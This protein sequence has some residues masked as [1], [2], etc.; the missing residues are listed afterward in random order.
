LQRNIKKMKKLRF[1]YG[2]RG[3]M[4]EVV[5]SI[6][7]KAYTQQEKK[8]AWAAELISATFQIILIYLVANILPIPLLA[9]SYILCIFFESIL[10]I[11]LSAASRIILALKDKNKSN[12]EIRGRRI[13]LIPS[14]G[15]WFSLAVIALIVWGSVGFMSQRNNH[16]SEKGQVKYTQIELLKLEQAEAKY[17]ADTAEAGTLLMGDKND[18]KRNIEDSFKSKFEAKNQQIAS[19]QRAINEAMATGDVRTEIAARQRLSNANAIVISKTKADF[20]Q[21][22]TDY[23]LRINSAEK[24]RIR[25]KSEVS[26]SV[27]GRNALNEFSYFFEVG[28]YF[29]LVICVAVC[30]FLVEEHKKVAN[31]DHFGIES[32]FYANKGIKES[33]DIE[34]EITDR[35]T[36]LDIFE[37]CGLNEKQ[38]TQMKRRDSPLLKQAESKLL[39]NGYVLYFGEGKTYPKLKLKQVA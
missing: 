19:A 32:L 20:T 14:H 33:V 16:E 9:V 17:K 18:V 30:I 24:E 23:Q 27:E 34:I 31:L 4:P 28:V 1:L 15:I 11:L 5:K 3:Y 12:D 25:A 22:E 13:E 36:R 6:E 7:T 10:R 2:T 8:T 29:I 26:S 37:R 21:S 38:L 39:K 35:G